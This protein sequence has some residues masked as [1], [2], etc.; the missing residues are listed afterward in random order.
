MDK[1]I[2]GIALPGVDDV[3]MLA[4]LLTQ[5]SREQRLITIERLQAYIEMAEQGSIRN[6]HTGSS[7][8][9]AG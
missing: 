4:E 9:Q 2:N 7:T 3:K 6:L 5:M 8:A 1:S